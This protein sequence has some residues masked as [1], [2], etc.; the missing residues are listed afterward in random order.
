LRFSTLFTR[1]EWSAGTGNDKTI[2]RID[3]VDVG[4]GKNI[5]AAVNQK[6]NDAGMIFR[7][8]PH[9]SRFTLDVFCGI[10]AG[11]MLQ[12]NSHR[13]GLARISGGHQQGFSACQGAVRARTGFQQQFDHRRVAINCSQVQRNRA[14]AICGTRV[15]AGPDQDLNHFEV[16]PSYCPMQSSGSVH[17]RGVDVG[18]LLQ[19]SMDPF[20]VPVHGG[21]GEPGI[22]SLQFRQEPQRHREKRQC[23][24]LA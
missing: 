5:G 22:R 3:Q 7:G 8:G 14:F 20:F 24:F 11:A 16:I 19:Q 21:I 4:A 12:Q 6:L 13:I 1:N 23:E 9:Q 18:L 17:L 15:G 10:N 2:R